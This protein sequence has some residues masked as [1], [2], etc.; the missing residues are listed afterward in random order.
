MNNNGHSQSYLVANNPKNI[1][2][3]INQARYSR[4]SLCN[5]NSIWLKVSI[6]TELTSANENEHSFDTFEAN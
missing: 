4:K 3:A 5:E 2:N 1:N 6:A